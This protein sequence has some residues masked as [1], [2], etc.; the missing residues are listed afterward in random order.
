MD[1]EMDGR[2]DGRTDGRMDRPT[3]GRT[4]GRRDERTNE[5]DGR[6]D[7]ETDGRTDGWTG[8]IPLITVMFLSGLHNPRKGGGELYVLRSEVLRRET[9]GETNEM[10]CPWN[11]M[12]CRRTEA[13]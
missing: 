13:T 7:R 12:P 1:G 5:T 10:A 4:D 3:D 2:M 9:G 8:K 11:A 6:T